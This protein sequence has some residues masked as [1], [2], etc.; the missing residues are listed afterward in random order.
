MEPD[1]K[2]LDAYN[3]LV[4]QY[5]E[6]A[7]APVL[8]P[9]IR[10]FLRIYGTTEVDGPESNPAILAWRDEIAAAWN[11]DLSRFRTDSDPWCSL[12]FAICWKRAPLPK[13]PAPLWSQT[14]LHA[15]S[16]STIWERTDVSGLEKEG[17]PTD[18]RLGDYAIFHR[19]DPSGN[20][21]PM[22]HVAAIIR[23]EQQVRTIHCIGA[24]QMTSK[25][26][27]VSTG[28]RT[29]TKLVAIRRPIYRGVAAAF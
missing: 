8:P 12:G 14:W 9:L 3:A 10:E 13:T 17:E 19:D 15:P 24:N 16:A 26:D 4:G 20:N 22:G 29:L 27:S 18:V 2:I 25:G 23:Y 7:T 28:K 11:M 1:T 5:P 6:L 21:R